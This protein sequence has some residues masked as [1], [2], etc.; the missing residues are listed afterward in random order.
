[1]EKIINKNKNPYK[2]VPLHLAWK[3]N[4]PKKI[5]PEIG[6]SQQVTVEQLRT[7]LAAET[8]ARQALERDATAQTSALSQQVSEWRLGDGTFRGKN[9][10]RSRWIW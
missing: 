5:L 4:L 6:T 10:G 1:M 9:V 2:V 8:A 7:A 3:K